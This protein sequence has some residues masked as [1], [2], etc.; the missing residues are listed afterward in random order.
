MNIFAVLLNEFL[1]ESKSAIFIRKMKKKCV[2]RKKRPILHVFHC[3]LKL[4]LFFQFE[5]IIFRCSLPKAMSISRSEI[6]RNKNRKCPI[7]AHCH[8]HCR[9]DSRIS[10]DFKDWIGAKTQLASRDL[11]GPG[12]PYEPIFVGDLLRF[13]P[14][15]LVL[16]GTASCSGL[17]SSHFGM[18]PRREP[19]IIKV[20]VW[21]LTQG[22]PLLEPMQSLDLLCNGDGNEHL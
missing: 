19:Q 1:N 20:H 11:L 17:R 15:L 21:H 5:W 8:R 18:E 14:D 12:A 10:K 16:L 3:F 7:D 4:R 9:R 6:L 13:P 2:W 22:G